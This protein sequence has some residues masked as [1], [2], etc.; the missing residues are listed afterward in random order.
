VWLGALLCL[1]VTSTDVRGQPPEYRT[2]VIFGD[3]Q[4]LSVDDPDA[5]SIYRNMVRWVLKNREMQNID[6]VLHV[7]DIVKL[8]HYAYCPDSVA[9]DLPKHPERI[10][11]QWT[12]I[13]GERGNP[14]RVGWRHFEDERVPYAIVAGNHDNPGWLIRKGSA[15]ADIDG[16]RHY[17][18]KADMAGLPAEMGYLGSYEGSADHTPGGRDDLEAGAAHAWIFPLGAHRVLVVGSTFQL[19]RTGSC[20]FSPEFKHC[21]PSADQ[22]R[23]IRGVLADHPDKPAIILGHQLWRDTR[24]A[25]PTPLWEE[26]VGALSSRDPASP[27]KTVFMAAQGHT[28]IPWIVTEDVGGSRSAKGIEGT[29]LLKTD[30][31]AGSRFGTLDILR[32]Y[33]DP[34]GIDEISFHRMSFGTS[35]EPPEPNP[36]RRPF[37]IHHDIDHDG[38]LDGDDNCDAVR[39]DQSDAD[40]DGVGDA[41]EENPP[42]TP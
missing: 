14:A 23:W 32:F 19:H 34:E 17:F 29:Q 20:E 11:R 1:L 26:I 13:L 33:F 8:G 27:W 18:G 21:L 36:V 30:S 31:F 42:A 28:H 7:G 12:Q 39:N 22:R 16:F 15:R 5:G 10:T 25:A 24:V 3:T 38:I 9:C 35:T 41:C 2:V 37:S 4:F 6:F 40:G